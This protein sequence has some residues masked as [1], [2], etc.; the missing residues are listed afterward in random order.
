MAEL[1]HADLLREYLQH[2]CQPGAESRLPSWT[3]WQ[4]LRLGAGMALGAV[5][6]LCGC[7]NDDWD[8]GTKINPSN[9]SD[10]TTFTMGGAT[11]TKHVSVRGGTVGEVSSESSGGS[12]E[13]TNATSTNRGGSGSSS[14]SNTTQ[15]GGS[16]SSV[17]GSTSSSA[18]PTMGGGGDKYGIFM[19]GGAG[20]TSTVAS[21]GLGATRTSEA[22]GAG[23]SKYGMVM[24]GGTRATSTQSSSGSTTPSYGSVS[25]KYGIPMTTGGTGVG[26]GG[27]SSSLGSNVALYAVAMAELDPDERPG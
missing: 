21:G 2:F 27:S 26:L 3:D 23:G 13:D 16:G 20:I 11:N 5:L 12:N 15:L 7:S 19:T 25:G 4:R 6:A 24:T 10:T 1:T 17:G 9:T 14:I 18:P 8:E 22:Y